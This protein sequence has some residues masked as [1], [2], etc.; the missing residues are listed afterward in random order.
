MK[1]RENYKWAVVGLCFLMVFVRLGFCSSNKSLGLA[2]ITEAP[3][4]KR[5]A[6]SVND[7]I[8]YITTAIVNIFFGTPVGKFGTYKPVLL[9]L[10]G[11][12][13]LVTAMF[14]I[15]INKSHKYK[16]RGW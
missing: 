7:S 10:C 13:F 11:V 2:P 5:S 4:I 8:R 12:M 15:V 1:N 3:G 16:E 6:F 14:Q 9:A